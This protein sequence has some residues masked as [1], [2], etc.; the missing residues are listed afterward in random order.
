MEYR[1]LFDQNRKPTGEKIA[2]GEKFGKGKYIVV[3]MV[4]IENSRG[5]MLL[6]KRSEDKGGKW[7]TTGGHPTSGQSSVE[8]MCQE[9]KEELGVNVEQDELVLFETIKS[10]KT[11]VD[12]YYLKKDIN[13]S[14]LKLQ[15]SEVQD[16][17]WFTKEQVKDLI[18]TG[19][20]FTPHEEEF[21]DFLKFDA[22]NKENIVLK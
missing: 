9:L 12:L 18:K 17:G 3:V 11:F 7:A 19:Q 21:F 5:E 8:G 4:F 20:F 22:E 2:K 6:Q 14:D 16:A 1:D 13:L 10:P 15:Q